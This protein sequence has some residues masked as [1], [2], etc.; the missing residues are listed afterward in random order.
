[1]CMEPP[2]PLHE[3]VRLA[4]SSAIIFD[5]SAPFATMCPWPRC[6]LSR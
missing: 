2:F 4:Y 6:V 1:M 3:P 5:V